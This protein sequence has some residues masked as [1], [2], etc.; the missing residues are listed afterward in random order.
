M[1]ANWQRVRKLVVLSVGHPTSY[2]RAGFRQKLLGWY[3][4]YFQL[5]GLAEPKP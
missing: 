3:T 2:G 1:S 5:V 4:L